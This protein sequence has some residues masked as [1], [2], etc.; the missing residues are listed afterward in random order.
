LFIVSASVHKVWT[1]DPHSILGQEVC[2]TNYIVAEQS[3]VACKS[4]NCIRLKL[5]FHPDL[6]WW[7]Q[8]CTLVVPHNYFQVR[9]NWDMGLYS[10]PIQPCWESSSR[11]WVQRGARLCLENWSW[12]CLV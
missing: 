10:I 9:C 1:L 3:K 11:L 12:F 6:T 2:Q 7:K 8:L 5:T 4:W